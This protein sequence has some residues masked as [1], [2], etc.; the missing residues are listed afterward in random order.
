MK[1]RLGKVV[2]D[3][4]SI[5][6]KISLSGIGGS[7]KARLAIGLLIP[8]L[9]LAVY[10]FMSYKKSE[11][12][13][14]NNY[15][16][17]ASDTI[18]AINK[19]M[20]LGLTMAEQSSL[21]M[22]LDINF[23][24]FFAL[25]LEDALGRTKSYDDLRDRISLSARSNYF[26]SNI[27]IIAAN[28][29]SISTTTGIKN[30]LYDSVVES[31]IGATFK[32]KN[33][34]YLWLGNHSELDTVLLKEGS[35]GLEKYAST[36]IR[37][38]SDN[39][40]YII[41]D[42]SGDKIKEMFNNYDMGEGSI[43][44]Y[45]TSDGRETLAN[46]N[47]DTVFTN[48]T[49]FQKA[50]D[51]EESHGY[52][53]EKYNGKQYLFIFS[54]LAG[55]QGTICSLIPKSTIL[56]EVSG[57]RALSFIFVT[58]ASIVAIAIVFLITKGITKTIE[59]M[60]E[61][62]S[63]AAKGDLTVEFNTNRKDEFN[64][65][66]K[67]ISDMI[68]HMSNLIGDVQGVGGTVSNSA[69]HLSHTS[70]ELLEATRG[71][72]A[73]IDDIGGG[74]IH[75][76]EDAEHCLIQMSGLSDQI[77]QLYENTNENEKIANYTQ[78]VTN[79]GIHIIEELNDKSIA[80][81][82]ITQDVILKIQEFEVQSKKI[83][84][85]V[86]IINEI[87]SQTNLLSL[88][89]S[90]EAARAGEAG[91]G[92]A[93]VAEEIRKLADQSMNAANQIQNTV[94]DIALQNKETVAT[95]KMAENIVASQTD[96]LKKT[97]SVFDNISKHVNNLANN[98]KSI[99]VRLNNIESVKEETL[100]SIQNISAVTEETAAASEEMNATALLQTESVERLRESVIIL[101]KDSKKLEDAIKIF[102]VSKS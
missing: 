7:I 24:E 23:K 70:S 52:S 98:F 8:I 50:L 51:S 48:L 38:F 102:K 92:F 84:S 22:I 16:N 75:Q 44:G 15:E 20:N 85:F 67:G 46:T 87:A 35:Y 77:S 55:N 32:E 30:H 53:Y 37:R 54:K 12:A 71:I 100:N 18:N 47:A 14:I 43:Q 86:N 60:N 61:S 79:D 21:E 36:I 62:I 94:A 72:S 25:S 11:E 97:I 49:Y 3:F 42:I 66:S 45:I 13:I 78:S 58:V 90:I 39:R 95:A 101:E 28:G 9:F 17:S 80:T 57:I 6:K 81:S 73:T 4:K 41:F 2:S 31:S 40:G 34:Q 88:N 91:R 63:L 64:T 82:E 59:G 99:L 74:I 5:P 76:A 26:I 19:Y 96:S 1:N 68:N 89:A 56:K 93:V 29:V 65:L 33:T 83:E 69:R 10:G 27:H